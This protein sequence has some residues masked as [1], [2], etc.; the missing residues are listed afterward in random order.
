MKSSLKIVLSLTGLLFSTG[1]SVAQS[2]GEGPIPITKTKLNSEIQE[3]TEV[4]RNLENSAGI[5]KR[6]HNLILQLNAE[7]NRCKAQKVS[8]HLTFE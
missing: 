5:L 2:S 7:L 1:F 8:R 4:I 6:K 3:L